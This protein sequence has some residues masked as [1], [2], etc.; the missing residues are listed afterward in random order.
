MLHCKIKILISMNIPNY[1]IHKAN[2]LMKWLFFISYL[3]LKKFIPSLIN[4]NKIQ[5]TITVRDETL[6]K[7]VILFYSLYY[8]DK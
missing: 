8:L 3:N 6:S 4:I 7:M 1:Y 2:I 5:N